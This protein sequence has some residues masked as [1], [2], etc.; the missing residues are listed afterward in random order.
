MDTGRLL[1]SRVGMTSGLSM[2][3]SSRKTLCRYSPKRTLA[4]V[5]FEAAVSIGRRNTLVIFMN[6]SERMKLVKLK[7]IVEKERH[8]WARVR[9]IFL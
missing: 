3:P 6:W 2:I 7:G 9:K 5:L 1:Q 4:S 8:E